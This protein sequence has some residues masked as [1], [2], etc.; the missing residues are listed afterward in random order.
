MAIQIDVLSSSYGVGFPA[1]YFRIFRT[2]ISRRPWFQGHKHS[3]I[4]DILGYAAPP[5]EEE[6]RDIDSKRFSAPLSDIEAQAGDDFIAKCYSWLM[7]QPE[8]EGSI[9]V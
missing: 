8:L 2:E 3:V 6:T 9:A 1:A 4:I 7:Q 5:P